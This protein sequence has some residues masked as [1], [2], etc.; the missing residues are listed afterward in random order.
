[1]DN[2][3]HVLEEAQAWQRSFVP[4]NA[5]D[6]SWVEKYAKEQFDFLKK[7]F[8]DLD[9][10]ATAIINYLTSAAGVFTLGSTTALFAGKVSSWV[11][12]ASLPAV[13]LA[14][15]AVGV[16]SWCRKPR[17]IRPTPAPREMVELAEYEGGRFQAWMM[18][19]LWNWSSL[20]LRDQVERKG[21]LLE[22][23]TL[24][25]I[26]AVVLLLLPLIVGLWIGPKTD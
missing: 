8:D 25:M 13:A 18:I 22:R 16:A 12:F 17:E 7:T 20:L 14:I 5:I 21:R 24:L 9:A 23:A 4:K 2:A 10:K 6:Y 11:I 19:P 26:V 1:M 3:N 15:I